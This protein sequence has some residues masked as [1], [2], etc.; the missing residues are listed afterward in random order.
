MAFNPPAPTPE[1]WTS[2][3]SVLERSKGSLGST[4][5]GAGHLG[6]GTIDKVGQQVFLLGQ[7]TLRFHQPV[8][9]FIGSAT[10]I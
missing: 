2:Q 3:S 8:S 5:S 7:L 6:E 10:D 9:E 4:S 1:V